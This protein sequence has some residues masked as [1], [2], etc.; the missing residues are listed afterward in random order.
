MNR[1]AISALVRHQRDYFSTGATLS[2]ENRIRVLKNLHLALKVYEPEFAAAVQA[3]LGKCAEETYMC[4]TGLIDP[5]KVIIGGKGDAETL[6]IRAITSRCIY[7]GGCVNDCVIH[8]ATSH[9]GFGGV[10]ESGMGAYHGKTG[11]D[12]FTHYK[13]IVDKKT[14]LD[15]PMLYQPYTKLYDWMIHLFLR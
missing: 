12:T 6:K 14:W 1:S 2:V 7:G 3:D 15:L 4:E 13:S 8:L 11:F 9:M 5:A 10:G